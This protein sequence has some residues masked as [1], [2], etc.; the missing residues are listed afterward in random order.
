MLAA[1]PHEVKLL[2]SLGL[3]DG[4]VSLCKASVKRIGKAVSYFSNK[5]K[6]SGLNTYAA[7]LLPQL[8]KKLGLKDPCYFLPCHSHIS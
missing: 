1:V 4:A 3:D 2:P 7:Q 5:R 8:L 6:H